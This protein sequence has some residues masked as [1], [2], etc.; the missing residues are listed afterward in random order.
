MDKVHYQ[1]KK[2]Y[3]DSHEFYITIPTEENSN[4]ESYTQLTEGTS[5][6]SATTVFDEKTALVKSEIAYQDLSTGEKL[7]ALNFDIHTCSILGVFGKILAFLASLV[8]GSLPV[9]GFLIWWG[10]KNKK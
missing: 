9:T 5:Y 4:F 10:R 8:A 6:N 7:N 2:L 3:P 1:L